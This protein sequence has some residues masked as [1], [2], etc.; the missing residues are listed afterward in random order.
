MGVLRTII[1]GVLAFAVTFFAGNIYDFLTDNTKYNELGDLV[2]FSYSPGYSDMNGASHIETLKYD[3]SF[4]WVYVEEDREG[5]Q[6]SE[7]Q[8]YKKADRK[9]IDKT[10]KMFRSLKGEKISETLENRREDVDLSFF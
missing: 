6:I 10:D 7:Y 5:Y 8:D 1:I 9:L 3:D 2:S 4:G